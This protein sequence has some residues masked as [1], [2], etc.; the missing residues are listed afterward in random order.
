ML[1]YN[2]MTLEMLVQ[3]ENNWSIKLS[4]CLTN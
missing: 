1:E 3:F 2:N 4:D